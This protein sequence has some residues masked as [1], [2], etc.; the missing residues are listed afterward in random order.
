MGQ[1]KS[2]EIYVG[3]FSKEFFVDEMS[4]DH[5]LNVIVLIDQKI[6]SILNMA[7]DFG[8]CEQFTALRSCLDADRRMLANELMHRD[9]ETNCR[10]NC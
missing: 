2:R 8:T 7:S 6:D 1:K 4:N 5:I 10:E 3:G 9:A